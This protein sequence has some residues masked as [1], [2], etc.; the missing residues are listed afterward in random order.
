MDVLLS[1]RP[2]Y[3]DAIFDG[4]KK[5]EVRSTCPCIYPDDWVY[6][7][8]TAPIKQ[9]VGR[10]RI[11]GAIKYVPHEYHLPFELLDK[12]FV[13]D[14]TRYIYSKKQ[15]YLWK[16]GECEAFVWPRSLWEFQLKRHPRSW[17]YIR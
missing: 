17:C 2:K 1:L 13:D 14:Y 5:Y 11:V 12:Q 10:I 9:I 8:S 4:T 7:Y 6:I 3:V 15:I 16:I